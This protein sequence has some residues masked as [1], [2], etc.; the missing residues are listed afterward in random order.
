MTLK[1]NNQLS[2]KIIKQALE[3][4]ANSADIARPIDLKTSASY[5]KYTRSK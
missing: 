5:A 4:G 2:E 1:N 3:F